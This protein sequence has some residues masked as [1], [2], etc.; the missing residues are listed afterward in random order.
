MDFWST[1]L[2]QSMDF[3]P[4]SMLWH[5]MQTSHLCL[6][7]KH[8]LL[9]PGFDSGPN[10]GCLVSFVFTASVFLEK[11]VHLFCLFSGAE[12]MHTLHWQYTVT[13]PTFKISRDEYSNKR[14]RIIF[15]GKC[16]CST[17]SHCP[18]DFFRRPDNQCHR[19][20]STKL[21]C[22]IIWTEIQNVPKINT[23][24]TKSVLLI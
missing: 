23:S 11:P 6:C 12:A 20:I 17:D 10:E 7:T 21:V 16:D 2:Q 18:V 24:Y 9:T 1:P 13:S 3:S 5:K 19:R 14:I 8:G 15:L 22:P 4:T